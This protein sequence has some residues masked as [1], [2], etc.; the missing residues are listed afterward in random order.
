M[1]KRKTKIRY[2]FAEDTKRTWNRIKNSWE[3]RSKD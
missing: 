2:N 3:I 1:A